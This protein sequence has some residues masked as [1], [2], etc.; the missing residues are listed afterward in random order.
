MANTLAPF[1]LL[2]WRGA[3]GAAPTYGLRTRQIAY[4]DTNKVFRGDLVASLSTGYIGQWTAGVA[5]SQLAGIFWGAKYMSVSQNTTVFSRYWPGTDVASTQ[6][7]TAYIIPCATAVPPMF[8]GQTANSSTTAVAVGF[9]D[10]GQNFDVAVGTGNTLSGASTTY[11][12]INTRNTT[13]TLPFRM[14]GYYDG[15]GNG[16]DFA[17]AY[18]NIIVQANIY[19]ETGI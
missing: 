12:D 11:L 14:I 17:S 5:V 1:G 10:I 15:P 2:P 4:N 13:A 7:V 9:G 19:Q 3:D 16:S 6:T 8:I 18:N